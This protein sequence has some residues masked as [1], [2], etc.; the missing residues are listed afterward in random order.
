M[1]SRSPE[2]PISSREPIET[3]PPISD[4]GLL[5]NPLKGEGSHAGRSKGFPSCGNELLT[6]YPH[7]HPASILFFFERYTLCASG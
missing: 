6:R 3:S 5:M 4:K 7:R 1:R 2:S